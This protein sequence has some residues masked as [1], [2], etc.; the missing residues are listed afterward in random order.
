MTLQLAHEF[1]HR[2]HGLHH[3]QYHFR[4]VD[5]EDS[6]NLDFAGDTRKFR[7]LGPKADVRQKIASSTP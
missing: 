7:D 1:A 5:L 6:R 4:L 2:Q 3:R